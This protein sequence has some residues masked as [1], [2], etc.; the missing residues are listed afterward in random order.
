MTESEQE[1]RARLLRAWNGAG[2]RLAPVPGREPIGERLARLAGEGTGA[3]DLTDWTDQY[4]NE[5]GIVGELERR[6]AAAL[7]TEA[8]AF[9]PTGTMAQQAALRCWAGRTGNDIVAL[10]PM[11]HPVRWERDALR[12]LAGLRV[13]HPTE[14]PRLPT[15]AEVR[16]VAEPFGSLAL[17]LPLRE[18]GFV[19][20]SWEELTDTVTAARDRDAVVHFD[21]A[22]LWECATH[23]GRSLPEI[24]SLA[25][26]VYVS[27]Y[28]SL[29]GLSGAALAG[30]SA[31]V[32]EAAAWRHRY[33]GALFQQWPAAL[34]ALVGL[35]R[36]LPRLPEYVAHAALVAQALHESLAASGVP[37]WLVW[38][39]VPH[40]HQF[41]V[42][43][44]Y[45][46]RELTDAGARQ[47][48][49]TGTLLFRR[50][51]EPAGAPPGMSM[52]EVTVAGPGLSWSAEDVRA[53]VGAFLGFLDAARGT[54]SG[55]G[56][57]TGAGRD[58]GPVAE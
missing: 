39:R 57:E 46:A 40:T 49:E 20:P 22:R 52:H 58:S 19:L 48:E 30:P 2:R 4:G 15:A 23:F 29:G 27:F 43:L 8:A 26:T 14:A 56:T 41:Q 18:A 42:W 47:A 11:A 38:P 3:Y 13:V 37:W 53:A 7:G 9:F 54:A 33:G 44:P 51:T 12:Q 6:T 24:A 28:K 16:D 34:A 32:Q 36:E 10:H 1:E 25:D 31:V 17:E 21:G 45:G 5:D 55:Q 35:D 50:W